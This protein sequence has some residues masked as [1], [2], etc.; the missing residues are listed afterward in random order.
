MR[1]VWRPFLLDLVFTGRQKC[2][3]EC[4]DACSSQGERE[5]SLSH[6]NVLCSNPQRNQ[7]KLNDIVLNIMV[8]AP[9][10]SLCPLS[11]LTL[12]NE[13]N[14]IMSKKIKNKSPSILQSEIQIIGPSFEIAQKIH[15]NCI[16]WSFLG[17]N[18]HQFS[19]TLPFSFVFFL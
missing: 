17:Q 18:D 10:A 11:I 16:L 3:I 15:K 13:R 8:G 2:P 5:H 4:L 7:P 14:Q 6:I 12:D 1:E 9:R 19:Y